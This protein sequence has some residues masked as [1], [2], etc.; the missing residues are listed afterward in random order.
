MGLFTKLKSLF[1]KET[2][3]DLTVPL[4]KELMPPVGLILEY[5]SFDQEATEVGDRAC[6]TVRVKN[7]E[8]IPE[9]GVLLLFFTE[10]D[11]IYFPEPYQIT[12]IEGYASCTFEMVKEGQT[13]VMVEVVY[14]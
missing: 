10:T 3:T 14:N 13:E 12:D 4:D 1:T 5:F 2:T 6:L 9:S 11:F 7:K 8:G